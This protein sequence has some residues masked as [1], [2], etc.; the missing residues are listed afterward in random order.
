MFYDPRDTLSFGQELEHELRGAW[1]SI[2]CEITILQILSLRCGYFEDIIGARGG[3]VYQNDGRIDYYSLCHVLTRRNLGEL[4][5]VG[6]CFGIGLGYKDYIRFN[7]S[8]DHRI[9]D[10]PT[11]NWKFTLTINNV[12]GMLQ[13]LRH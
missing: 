1:K 8:D 3:F 13:E 2:A 6:L 5:S 10:F 4:E 9:Y 7:V 12:Q 11:S